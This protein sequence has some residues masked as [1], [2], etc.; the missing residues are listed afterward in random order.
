M[1]RAAASAELTMIR[2]A[3]GRC[4]NCEEPVSY[5][6]RACPG[7]GASNLPNPVVIATAL[8]AVALV[9]GSIALGVHL[10][11]GARTPP[12]TAS[13]GA[14]APAADNSGTGSAS[15]YGW[16]V[17]AM[18]ECEE[19]A[20][21]QPDTMHFLIVP[22]R[23]SGMS[24]PG[25]SP[26]PISRV[27]EHVVLLNSADSLIGLRNR[28]LLLYQKPMTFAVSDPETSTV[29]K[30]KPAT[31]VTALKARNTGSTKLTLGFEIPDLAKDLAWGPT[32]NLKKGTCYWI[33]PLVRH[34]PRSG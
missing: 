2:F 4:R 25:W 27:G 17:A 6:A 24:L 11:R 7:C 21:I 5:F 31:G 1:L 8:A 9:G 28:A 20:K 34:T 3:L 30:W 18:A 15:D 22:L 32:I 23:T 16:I 13:S 14:P 33:N 19:E 29:Y 12:S 10:V 26:E